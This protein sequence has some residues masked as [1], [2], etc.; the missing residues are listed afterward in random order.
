MPTSRPELATLV[1][2]LSL[3]YLPPQDRPYFTSHRQVGVTEDDTTEHAEWD[4]YTDPDPSECISPQLKQIS[5]SP[6]VVASIYQADSNQ[7]SLSIQRVAMGKSPYFTAFCGMIPVKVTYDTGAESSLIRHSTAV[8]AGLKIL[9]TSHAARQADGS[10]L[11]TVGE[12][13]VTLTRDNLSF[14]TT[15]I[16]VPTLDCDILAVHNTKQRNVES[17]TGCMCHQWPPDSPCQLCY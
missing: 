10:P 1:V 17:C 11:S 13:T 12:T 8:K 6:P 4:Q 2:N 14:S 3:G 5:V 7:S 9:P 15:A 16:V